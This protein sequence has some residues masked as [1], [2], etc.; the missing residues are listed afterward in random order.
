[1]PSAGSLLSFAL[2]LLMM[3]FLLYPRPGGN[4]FWREK[5]SNKKNRSQDGL[6]CAAGGMTA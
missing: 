1:M 6:L 3:Y 2:L 5:I 4:D